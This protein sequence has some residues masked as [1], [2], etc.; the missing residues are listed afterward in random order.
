MLYGIVH[1][2][3]STKTLNIVS[4]S[5]LEYEGNWGN[6]HDSKKVYYLKLY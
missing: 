1:I 6:L 3:L 2:T 4:F 5:L